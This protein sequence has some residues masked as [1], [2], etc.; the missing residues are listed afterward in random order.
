MRILL[1]TKFQIEIKSL[2]RGDISVCVGGWIWIEVCVSHV[3]ECGR[4][5]VART[6]IKFNEL[7][8]RCGGR[9]DSRV[10]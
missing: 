3:S 5:C 4:F 2:R 7:F 1:R 10:W 6:L 9:S 8:I